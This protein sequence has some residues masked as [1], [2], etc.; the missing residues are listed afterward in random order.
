MMTGE[1]G[2]KR[3]EAADGNSACGLACTGKGICSVNTIMPCSV[4]G[5]RCSVFGVRCSVFKDCTG[6]ILCV[7]GF[8]EFFA[9]KL[10]KHSEG[11]RRVKGFSEKNTIFFV[12]EY[13][14]FSHNLFVGSTGSPTA[15]LIPGC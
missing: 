6:R 14:F 13:I 1:K 7:K 4:F 10:V 12:P 5:V 8:S 2:F 3:S 11:M 9:E 15:E